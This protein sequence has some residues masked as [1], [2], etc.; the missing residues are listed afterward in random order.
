MQT[1]HKYLGFL[2]SRVPFPIHMLFCIITVGRQ[3]PDPSDTSNGIVN[4]NGEGRQAILGGAEKR[5][6]L[7]LV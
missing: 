6:E 2:V 7:L 3:R 5:G 1:Y 4:K